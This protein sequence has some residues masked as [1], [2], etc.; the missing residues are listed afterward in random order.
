MCSPI[1]LI[2]MLDLSAQA[3]IYEVATVTY[4][5]R[6]LWGAF[7][8]PSIPA[9]LPCWPGGVVGEGNAITSKAISVS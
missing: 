1:G 5:V 4:L 7:I 8:T 6:L 3:I 2:S 9:L